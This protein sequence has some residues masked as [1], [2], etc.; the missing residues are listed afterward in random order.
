MIVSL[1]FSEPTGP[2]QTCLVFGH[3][4]AKKHL[5][6]RRVI[7]S[8]AA[9]KTDRLTD[10]AADDDIE[11]DRQPKVSGVPPATKLS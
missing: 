2:G 9:A 6:D 3:C 8:T 5:T 7:E 11:G 1:V 10:C 4:P